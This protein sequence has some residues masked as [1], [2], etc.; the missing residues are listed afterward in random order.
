MA[1]NTNLATGIDSTTDITPSV[2][3]S[4]QTDI[5]MTAFLIIFEARA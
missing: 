2:A 3:D 1:A 5:Q 4:Q